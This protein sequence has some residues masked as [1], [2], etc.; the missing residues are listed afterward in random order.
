[1]SRTHGDGRPSTLLGTPY[2]HP[3]RVSH[4]HTNNFDV[5]G[6]CRDMGV[7]SE[8]V[9][10]NAEGVTLR[11]QL[12]RHSSTR[13]PAPCV[14]ATHG[15]AGEISH[16]LTDFAES[17]AEAGLTTLVYDHRG[18]GTSDTQPGAPRYEIDP[19]QQIR[20]YQHAITYVQSVAGV[21]SDRIGVWGSSYSAGHVFVLGAIDRRVKAVVGQVPVISGVETFQSLVRIDMESTSHQAFAA[22]RRAR[23]SGEP[24]AVIPV[25]AKDP[26][27]GAALPTADAY[28]FFCGT[29]GV[30]E[31]DA[32]FANQVTLRSVEHMYGYEP[33]WYLP[34]I[35]PTPLL[36]IVAP[37]D[38]I[39]R[40]DLALR[41]FESASHPKKLVTIPGG[42]FDAYR[43]PSSDLARRA[44]RD[45]FVEQLAEPNAAVTGTIDG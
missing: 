18:W 29:G 17:F 11:G 9:E 45:W 39:A 5:I 34:R 2:V 7:E 13:G 10:F 43:G 19:W 30:I 6:V 1:M 23:A 44:A 42:H 40:A 25:V 27:A 35:S 15:F 26:Q 16:F 37:G 20:D 38:Q 33:G 28:E 4:P 22:D 36:M 41:S 32:G 31:R 21:D 14:I 3:W 12:F 8:E 24:A